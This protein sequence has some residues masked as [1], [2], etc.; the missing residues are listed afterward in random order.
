MLASA[1]Y[2][3]V[4]HAALASLVVALVVPVAAAQAPL[5]EADLV[6]TYAF[7][8]EEAEVGSFRLSTSFVGVITLDGDGTV[9]SGSR[10]FVRTVQGTGT[11]TTGP[12]FEVIQQE[13]TG[14]YSVLPDGTGT[15][16][17]TATPNPPWVQ[18]PGGCCHVVFGLEPETVYFA[19]SDAGR[20]LLLTHVVPAQNQFVTD[21]S[22]FG[23]ED[24]MF[25]G[26][27]RRADDPCA[28]GS[29]FPPGR[30]RHLGVSEERWER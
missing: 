20:T 8:S 7:S 1:P 18:N 22:L 14:T 2:R 25:I 4:T 11:L 19:V 24:R 30:G 16:T 23:H 13:V 9:V 6:G 27:A 21:P 3:F 10:A 26:R 17:L 15:M 28:G 29:G 5:T 12:I